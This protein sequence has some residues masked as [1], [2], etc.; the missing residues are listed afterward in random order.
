MQQT[1][2]A[3]AALDAGYAAFK[4][5]RLA[6]A[7]ELF[8]R[9]LAAADADATLP[10]NSLLV[11][12]VLHSLVVARTQSTTLLSRMPEGAALMDNAAFAAAAR[13]AWRS[14]PRALV[15]SQRL[16]AHMLACCN[17][18]T[19]FAPLTLLEQRVA[20]ATTGAKETHARLRRPQS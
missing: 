11:A 4:L 12:T 10:R 1:R 7:V 16:L 13:S 2:E 15:L 17:A 20:L 8:E 6:R 9:A 14:E 18:G 3:L 19:L 5:G